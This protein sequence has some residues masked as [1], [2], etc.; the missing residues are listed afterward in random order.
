MPIYLKIV[1]YTVCLLLASCSNADQMTYKTDNSLCQGISLQVLG[2]GGPEINDRLASSSYLIWVG[3]KARVLVD[4]GGGSSLNFEKSGADFN[5][6]EAILLSHL[7]VDH[8]AALP[9][10]V[11]AGY[12]TN[13]TNNLFIL[14]P[15]A[16][17]GFP[18]TEYFVAAFFSEKSNS[19]YPYLSDNFDRSNSD[20]FQ[21]MPFSIDTDSNIWQRKISDQIK[22]SAITVQHGSIPALAWRVD[23]GGC[24]LTF[25]GDFNGSSGH[26]E[27]LAKATDLLVV[28]NAIPESADGVAK[29][30][31]AK[32]SIIGQIAKKSKAKKLLLSHFMNRT[33]QVKDQSQQLIQKNYNKP[34][35]LATDLMLIAI[36]NP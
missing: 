18:S 26:L 34:I 16:G 30:L 33:R 12:F 3:G 7:H 5:D 36:D 32:P 11:K 31:H 15:T 23:V 25:S 20:E 27:K 1:F 29:Y 10:Y 9:V 13:R 35:I 6:L 2:S 21:V 4:A 22:V 24:S 19:V 14:G 8:S 17:G 28:H